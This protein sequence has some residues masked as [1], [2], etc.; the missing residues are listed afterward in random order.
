MLLAEASNNLDCRDSA[1]MHSSRSQLRHIAAG[2]NSC[3]MADNYLDS[4]LDTDIK[5]RENKEAIKILFHL[6]FKSR[7]FWFIKETI[8]NRFFFFLFTFHYES[9][10]DESD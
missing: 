4:I 3:S 1:D 2:H 5:K 8:K 9:V 6:R 7:T 10:F